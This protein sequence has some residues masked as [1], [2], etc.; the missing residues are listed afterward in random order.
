MVPGARSHLTARHADGAFGAA[1]TMAP[2]V[3]TPAAGPAA[4]RPGAGAPADAPARSCRRGTRQ[5]APRVLLVAPQPFFELRG[6]PINVLQMARTL[7]GAGYEVHLATY[8]IGQ[9]VTIPGLVHHRAARVP[10]IRS[11]SIGFSVQKVV[12]DVVLA[13]RVWALVLTHRFD[14]VHAVEESIFF[15]LPAAKLRRMPIIYDLDSGLSQ[16]LEYTGVVRN[17]GLLRAAEA[18]ERAAARHSDLAITVCQ[19]LTDLVRARDGRLPIVQIEDCPLDELLRDPDPRRVAELRRRFE[20][21]DGPVAVYTGNLEPYQGV[22]LLL[23]SFAVAAPSVPAA[24]LLVVG[25]QPHHVAAYRASAAERGVGERVVFAGQQ[26]PEAMAEFMALGSALVSPR[27][28]GDNTPLKLYSY[29]HSGVPIVA[30]DL[31]T[32]TQVLDRTTAVLAPATPDA[33]GHALAKVLSRPALYAP[34]GAAARR[35]VADRYSREAFAQKLL[36]A[37]ERLLG[38]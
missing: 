10:G 25:G 21:G 30:T 3:A 14:V 24:R 12:L 37:Y 32:H 18:L 9:P 7:C 13:L 17:R 6:T 22:S 26:P 28:A 11:V 35:Q 23:D 33:L 34:L 27:F 5:R 31:P 38:G 16:Q 1:A 19:S 8:G 4:R 2:A 20:L 15:A 36:G 29:M